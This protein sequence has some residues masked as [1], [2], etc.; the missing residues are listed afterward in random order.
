MAADYLPPD[1][2]IDT[3]FWSNGTLGETLV[4]GN[5]ST[6]VHVSPPNEQMLQ[7]VVTFPDSNVSYKMSVSVI[8]RN[9]EDCAYPSWT[10]F[11]GSECRPNRFWECS[12]INLR[13]SG[14]SPMCGIKCLCSVKCT[15]LHLKYDNFPGAG[16]SAGEICEIRLIPGLVEPHTLGQLVWDQGCGLLSWFLPFRYFPNFSE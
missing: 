13:N 14:R 10:W 2:R 4:D 11:A 5:S 8:V 7:T 12:K 9:T 1:R 16:G 6:C 15:Y 3:D